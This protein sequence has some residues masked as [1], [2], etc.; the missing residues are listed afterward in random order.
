MIFFQVV[1][2]NDKIDGGGGGRLKTY[3]HFFSFSIYFKMIRYAKPRFDENGNRILNI[4]DGQI[5]R[6]KKSHFGGSANEYCNAD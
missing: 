5:V 1:I 3:S 4:F 2:L 6:T